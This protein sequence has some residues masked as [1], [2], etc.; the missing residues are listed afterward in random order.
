MDF[1]KWLY[2][3]IRLK[4][5]FFLFSLG[6]ILVS[7]GMSL[8]LNY[9]YVGYLEEWLFKT[10]YLATG[11]YYYTITFWLAY[12]YYRWALVLCCLPQGRLFVPLLAP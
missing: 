6:T 8:L 4:R 1:L 5:W 9:Q 2:P 12:L 3:G 7:V 11:S 10:V